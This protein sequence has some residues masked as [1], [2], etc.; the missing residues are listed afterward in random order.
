MGTPSLASRGSPILT[1][2]PYA[3]R[4][5]YLKPNRPADQGNRP[6]VYQQLGSPP[7]A[8]SGPGGE[9]LGGGGAHG[10]TRLREGWLG[11]MI[12]PETH[13]SQVDIGEAAPQVQSAF[14]RA[15]VPYD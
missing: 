15:P 14:H 5:P 6:R 13:T 9:A 7:R 4:T 12:I 3:P 8:C 1:S 11:V 2:N 10:T